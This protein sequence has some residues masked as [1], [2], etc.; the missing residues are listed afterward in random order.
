[1]K[2]LIKKI[3]TSNIGVKLRNITGIKPVPIFIN[4]KLKVGSISDAYL[5]RTDNG[6]K[7]TYRYTD[8]LNLFYKE[9]GSY[10]DLTFYSKDNK[11]LKKITLHKLNFT[12]EL[13][14]DK[15]FLNGIE[16]FGVFYVFYGSKTNSRSDL[17]LSSRGYVGFSYKGNLSSFVHSNLY[18][19]YQSLDGSFESSDIIQTSLF[20]NI[21]RIQNL[22]LNFTKCELFF[23]NPSSKKIKFSIN[24]DK[25]SLGVNC[26]IIIDISNKKEILITSKC[27]FL[28]PIIFNYKDD[29]YDVYHA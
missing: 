21:Y 16:G 5:W 19:K 8:I 26:S 15:D 13:L 2:S 12:N 4:K 23:S 14:I 11:F 17:I 22:F 10:L 28:R 3:A 24:K 9:E 29:Y 25:Y 20:E 6:Y 27:M 1:M 7:T 18:A